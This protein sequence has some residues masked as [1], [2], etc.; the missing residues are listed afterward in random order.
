MDYARTLR[1]LRFVD[2]VFFSVYFLRIHV[3]P[4]TESHICLHYNIHSRQL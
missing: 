2:L 4:V 1:Q 3:G